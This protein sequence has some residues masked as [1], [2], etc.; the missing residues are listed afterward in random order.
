M[1]A[2]DNDDLKT[3]EILQQK[4]GFVFKSPSNILISAATQSGKS[5][6]LK[7][8]LLYKSG[9]FLN[10]P[11]KCLFYYKVWQ[12]LY[13]DIQNN[14]EGKI[15]FLQKFDSK[16]IEK[17]ENSFLVF[18]DFLY[19][20]DQE[21]VEIFLVSSHQKRLTPIFITQS[22]YF[23]DVLKTIRKNCH[24]Y[25]FLSHL[26]ASS[27]YRMMSNDITGTALKKFQHAFEYVM[28]EKMYTHLV[29][30]RLPSSKRD[31]RMKYDILSYQKDKTLPYV[32]KVF[33]VYD[34]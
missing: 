28:N 27:V 17:L 21:F 11:N 12:D 5:V 8:I 16:E 32:Y 4:D 2:K 1:D 29:Y 18:D 24:Y 33:N 19:S 26:D 30:D 7:D 9:L 34:E 22:L 6:F 23:N 10:A 25:I 14:F 13:D 15:V 3:Q 20:L 31:L